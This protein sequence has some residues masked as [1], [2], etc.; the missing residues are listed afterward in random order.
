[1]RYETATLNVP[2]ADNTNGTA[3]V[4]DHLREKTIQIVGSGTW[5]FQIQGSVDGVSFSA[6][7]S[8]VTAAGFQAIPQAIKQ[9]RIRRTSLSSGSF[10]AILAGFNAR[11]D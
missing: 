10:E 11:A 5:D 3:Q 8:S 2:T 6:L 9:V 1:M 4:C 7:V